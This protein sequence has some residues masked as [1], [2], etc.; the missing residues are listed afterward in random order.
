MYRA[1]VEEIIHTLNSVVG[2]QQAIDAGHLG[3]LSEDLVVAILEEAGKFANEELSPLNRIGDEHGATLENGVVTTAPGW[4]KTYNA[5]AE[6]GWNSLT[7]PE[8]FGG[9]GLPTMMSVA[10][11]EM[12]NSAA[13]AFGLAPLLTA[14]AIDAIHAHGSEELKNT[15]LEKM[16]SG[17]WTG[18][19]NL[20]EPHAGSYLASITSRAEPVGDG[21]FRI[22]GQKIFI[23][24]GEHDM[25]ENICHLVLARLPD[26]PKGTRG[27]SLFLVPK[28]LVNED[29]TL[30]RRND[31]VCQSLEHKLGI[32]A[33][34]TCVMIFGDD[35]DASELDQPG[36]VGYL[37]GEENRGL[38]CMFTMMNNARLHVGVQGVA[39]GE[40]AY[41]HALAYAN[42][43]TQGFVEGH[44]GQAPIVL[45][46]DVARNLLT[47]KSQV[48]AARTICYTCAHAA[49]MARAAK[50][51]GDNELAKKWSERVHIL[52]PVAKSYSTDIGVDVASIGVQIHGGMGFIEETGAAQFLRDARINPIY[53]GTNGIQAIDLVTR[54][55][56]LSGGQAVNDYY[57]ELAQ[58]V[59]T[60]RAADEPGFGSTAQLLA[61]TLADLRETTNWLLEQLAAGNN[62][63]VLAGATP[64][65]TMFGLT[66]GGTGLAKSGLATNADNPR[67]LARFFAENLLSQTRALK[68]TV[69]EGSESLAIAARQ[70]R[71]Q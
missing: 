32:H 38:N 31:V 64:F 54:K 68:S 70:L 37:V 5:W 67:E 45:H 61:S 4:K 10:V 29:G 19:M 66:A 49:D 12:W 71:L 23:T 2:L 52:T 40:A 15:Y 53:E 13:M 39:I 21:S 7:G 65:Q 8:E 1:P 44:E 14:G 28:I 48:Q 57:D 62:Q 60:I 30:G 33:S 36:A 34:P 22:F 27:I 25:T 3:D 18:T 63:A 51:A 6:G 17:K 59:E 43:R 9:Q 46:P 42:E 41:Q 50:N 26:A 56:P 11:S 55:L 47:M 69:M 24:Y 35:T 20:T 16:I 58:T